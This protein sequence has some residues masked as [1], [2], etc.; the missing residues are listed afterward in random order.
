MALESQMQQAIIQHLY[1]ICCGFEKLSHCSL[2][3]SHF[4]STGPQLERYLRVCHCSSSGIFLSSSSIFLFA[5]IYN[6]HSYIYLCLL[7]L[8]LITTTM[9]YLCEIFIFTV[10]YFD[11]N[12][13]MLL[14]NSY[15]VLVEYLQ[16]DSIC[17]AICFITLQRSK[18]CCQAQGYMLVPT[19]WD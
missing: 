8:P 16:Y 1:W 13:S 9:Y 17:L 19:L 4:V 10:I 12:L 7:S 11:H 5:R 14:L 2:I 18:I 15:I 3:L 6:Q